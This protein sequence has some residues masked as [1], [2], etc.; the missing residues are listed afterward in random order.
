MKTYSMFFIAVF[1]ISFLLNLKNSES[2]LLG[3]IFRKFLIFIGATSTNIVV[4]YIIFKN[5][6]GPTI[7]VIKNSI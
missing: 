2:G 6:V 4:F 7:E 3:R 1:I 5:E